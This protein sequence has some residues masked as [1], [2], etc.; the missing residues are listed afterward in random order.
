M[1]IAAGF[2]NQET[3]ARAVDVSI[4]TIS[5][6]ESGKRLPDAA[7]LHALSEK[8]NC[9]VDYLLLREDGSTHDVAHMVEYTGLSEESLRCL[10]RFKP[11]KTVNCFGMATRINEYLPL[12]DFLNYALSEDIKDSFTIMAMSRI[13]SAIHCRIRDKETEGNIDSFDEPEIK[14][15]RKQAYK[16]G[17]YILSPD[18]A[19]S[20]Y[21]RSAIG[22]IE[23]FIEDYIENRANQRYLEKKD[24]YSSLYC[25]SEKEE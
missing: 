19:T 5:A 20:H 7:T 11:D 3:L 13:E 23:D 18:S 2:S 15:L 8:L 21:I 17:Y 22:E 10:N 4:Q 6:Y 9:T 12:H 25:E 14:N 16:C 1:R 24:F